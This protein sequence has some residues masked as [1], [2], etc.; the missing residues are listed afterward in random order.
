MRPPESLT[1]S[2]VAPVPRPSPPPVFVHL[3]VP[4]HPDLKGAWWR[5]CRTFTVLSVLLQLDHCNYRAR[6]KDFLS[7]RSHISACLLLHDEGGNIESAS[8]GKPKPLTAPLVVVG[9]IFSIQKNIM[10]RCF[11]SGRGAMVKTASTLPLR[12]R[13]PKRCGRVVGLVGS[14]FNSEISR[15]H[16]PLPPGDF[17]FQSSLIFQRIYEQPSCLSIACKQGSDHSNNRA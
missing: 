3:H 17:L 9:G 7:L 14:D 12:R 4:R 2:N 6:S 10:L 13:I 15:I 8:T 16:L 5:G 1:G 11:Q